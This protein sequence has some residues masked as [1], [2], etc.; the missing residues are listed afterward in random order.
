[1]KRVRELKKLIE[2][3]TDDY[4]I[5]QSG[6]DHFRITLRNGIKSRKVFAP[7]SGS[8]KRGVKNLR[9]HIRRQWREISD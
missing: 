1:M 5:E 8:D 9:A 2:Q 3:F 6:G 4:D 7:L